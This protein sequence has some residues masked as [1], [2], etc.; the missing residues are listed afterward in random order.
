MVAVRPTLWKRPGKE[1]TLTQV[2]HGTLSDRP[3][4]WE[5][6]SE[7]TSDHLTVDS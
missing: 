3:I 6:G 5:K 2:A 1:A 4:V 7:N